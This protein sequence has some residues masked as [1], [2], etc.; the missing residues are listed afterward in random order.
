MSP[1]DVVGLQYFDVF[2]E[3]FGNAIGAH[4]IDRSKDEDE[5]DVR[6]GER[7]KTYLCKAM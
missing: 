2:N 7:H 6:D 4:L 3:N 1:A 5:D